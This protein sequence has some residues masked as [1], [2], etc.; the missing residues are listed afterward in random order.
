MMAGVGHCDVDEVLLD[1]LRADVMAVRADADPVLVANLRDA[2]GRA[3]QPDVG[4]RSARSVIR[5]QKTSGWKPDL[6]R[7]GFLARRGAANCPKRDPSAKD[8]RLESPTYE[9]TPLNNREVEQ[10]GRN[11]EEAN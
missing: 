10:R 2:V 8:V 4:Q 11:R 6:R 5:L 9:K 1:P 3:F 7:S